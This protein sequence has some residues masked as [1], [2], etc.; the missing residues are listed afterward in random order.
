MKPVFEF[1]KPFGLYL[2]WGSGY[3]LLRWLECFADGA[4]MKRQRVIDLGAGTG[5]AGI[6]SAL[7]GGVVTFADADADRQ[8]IARNVKAN[9]GHMRVQICHLAYSR[10]AF[11][12][13][14]LT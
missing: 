9:L 12:P 1:F 7:H 2:R 14:P 11:D 13:F 8:L 5:V 3:Q 4:A 10:P 6:F